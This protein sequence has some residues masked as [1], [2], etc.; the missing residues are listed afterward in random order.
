MTINNE[1]NNKLNE[2]LKPN[3]LNFLFDN[4]QYKYFSSFYKTIISEHIFT[5]QI[6]KILLHY[7]KE[8]N[9]INE[10]TILDLENNVFIQFGHTGVYA[11]HNSS[12][13]S[14]SNLKNSML[15]INYN[16]SYKTSRYPDN[17]SDNYNSV[18]SFE[19]KETV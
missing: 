15:T 2:L 10:N 13:K 4:I 12:I 7:F 1:L 18:S 16:S 14:Y 3:L 9:N 8:I 17:F 6:E 11:H 5:S 19:S